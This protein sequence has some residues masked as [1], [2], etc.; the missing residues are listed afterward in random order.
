MPVPIPRLDDRSFPDLVDDLLRR[1]PSHTPE[2]NNPRVGDPGRTLLEL[3][4]WLGDTILYRANLIPERQRLAFLT[5]LGMPMRSAQAA[6]G[7]IALSLDDTAKQAVQLVPLGQVG[8]PVPF[9][10]LSEVTVFRST[11]ECYY[12]RVLTADETTAMEAL[13]GGLRDLYSLDGQTIPY[14]TT[15]VF[16]EQAEDFDLASDAIDQAV[17]VALLAPKGLALADARAE[18]E[19]KVLNIGINPAID[20]PQPLDEVGPLARIPF[21]VAI[22]AVTDQGT[23]YLPLDVL[24]DSSQGLRRQGVIR[25]S[26]P[27]KDKMSAPPNDVRQDLMAG[28]GE[29][30]P[31]ID[32]PDRQNRIVAWLRLRPQQTVDRLRFSWICGHAVDIDQFQT[33]T[34]KVIGVSD[35]TADQRM[36]L[37]ATSVDAASFR[38][39]VEEE[40][41]G[42]RP[43]S[44]VDDLAYGTRDS[45]IHTLDPEAGAVQF[46][47]G[48]RGAIPPAGYRVRVAFMRAGGGSAGNLPAKSLTDIKATDITGATV[49]AKITVTQFIAT[50]G[51][52][53]S[54]KLTDAQ[55]RIPGFLRHANR[56]VTESD[57]TQLAAETPGQAVGRVELLPMFVPQQRRF[58]TPGVVTVMAIPAR[59]GFANPNP[60]ADRPFLTAIDDYLRPRKPLATEL[61]VIG[62]EYVPLGVAVGVTVADGFGFDETINNVRDALRIT[63]WPLAPG[64]PNGA[65]WPLGRT[66]K[67]LELEVAV[68]RVPGV[69]TVAGV[70]LFGSQNQRWQSIAEQA[71]AQWQLPEVLAIAVSGDGTVPS[72]LALPSPLGQ[73]KTFGV[74][75]VPEVC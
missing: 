48:M 34:A 35:G 47:D 73:G 19:G 69:D 21:E 57:I 1:I 10:T 42:W 43:W 14:V 50:T 24:S 49:T 51:G 68:A 65:G 32:D 25:I 4:A 64:G 23:S 39:E 58:D 22:S 2:Y 38:L 62:C 63:L 16:A 7:I 61:Y 20:V 60:R 59:A 56:A 8:G 27:G 15:R 26:L 17:W 67:A 9:E 30:P 37:P 66:V 6:S 12:K 44:R 29:N 3:V 71:L 72:S 41:Y 31:R 28:V 52:A 74:P 33:I 45:K 70:Q 18:L 5:L 40:G 53:D 55:K 11:V 36:Q 75:V 13:L 54:E 46:G